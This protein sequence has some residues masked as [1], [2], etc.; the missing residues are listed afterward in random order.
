MYFMPPIGRIK[1]SLRKI[2]DGLNVLSILLLIGST[3][4]SA[5]FWLMANVFYPESIAIEVGKY[6]LL[7]LIPTTISTIIFENRLQKVLDSLRHFRDAFTY[8][9][10]NCKNLILLDIPSTMVKEIHLVDGLPKGKLFGG[11]EKQATCENARIFIM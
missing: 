11:R 4:T 7:I 8:P 6:L 3:A 5:V 10:P 2:H 1:E 9:C